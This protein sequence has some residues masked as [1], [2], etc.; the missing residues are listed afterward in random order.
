MGKKSTKENKTVYQLAREDNGMT[1]ASAAEA[2]N[3]S[4][5]PFLAEGRIEKI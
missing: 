1:R 3:E 4:G 5:A 2:F